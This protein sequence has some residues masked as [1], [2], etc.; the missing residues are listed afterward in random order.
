MKAFESDAIWKDV[1]EILFIATDP[2]ELLR[3]AGICRVERLV[4]RYLEAIL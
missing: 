2:E 4:R 3:F 1:A